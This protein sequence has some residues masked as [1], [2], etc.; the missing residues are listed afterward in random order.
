[1]DPTSPDEPAAARHRTPLKGSLVFERTPAER[2]DHALD[3]LLAAPPVR[4]GPAMR[5]DQELHRLLVT[6]GRLQ[7]ALAPVPISSR[8]EAR[9]A[10]RLGSTR[11]LAPGRSPGWLHLPGWLVLTGALSSAAVGVGVTA[12]AVWRGRGRAMTRRAGVR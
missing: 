1:M 3:G 9:L 12:Y 8:F 11:R 2:L 7:H 4:P 5:G 10:N 6:A